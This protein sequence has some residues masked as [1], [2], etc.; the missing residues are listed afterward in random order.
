METFCLDTRIK[1][2]RGNFNFELMIKRKFTTK[3]LDENLILCND[4]N[5]SNSSIFKLGSR[6]PMFFQEPKEVFTRNTT[7]L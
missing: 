7:V 6:H 4:Q 1:T 3:I 5:F 2:T